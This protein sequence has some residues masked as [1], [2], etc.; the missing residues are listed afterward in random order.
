[1][2]LCESV[3]MYGFDA[4]TASTSTPYHYFD[5]RAAMTSVHSFDLAMEVYR[6]LGLHAP[7]T[8]HS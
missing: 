7:V 4:Y 5:Q 2:Q 8:V 1:M 3:D 6:R